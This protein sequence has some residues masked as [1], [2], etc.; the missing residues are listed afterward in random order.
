MSDMN[1]LDPQALCTLA[2]LKRECSVD[3]SDTGA[4][5]IFYYLINQVSE[6][7]RRHCN[8]RFFFD[9]E[10]AS[11]TSV[12]NA[13]SLAGGSLA[14]ATQPST[15]ALIVSITSTGITAGT[16]TFV[17][18]DPAGSAQ[19]DVYNFSTHGRSWSGVKLFATLTSITVAGLAG[20]VIT[21]KVSIG[22][23]NPYTEFHTIRKCRQFIYTR[24]APIQSIASLYD[25]S[26]GDYDSSTILDVDDYIASK[27]DGKIWRVT[28]NTPYEFESGIR[29]VKLVYTAGL[30]RDANV[31]NSPGLL[32]RMAMQIGA[33]Y[34]REIELKTQ[35]ISTKIDTSGAVLKFAAHVLTGAHITNEQRRM[36]S[37]FVR[38]RSR[39]AESDES[40]LGLT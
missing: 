18:T 28:S 26:N 10:V 34:Y 35:G 36:L 8:R 3:D 37:T 17:G 40:D 27:S 21:D 1:A 6:I 2:H 23:R 13:A 4:D 38:P 24:E 19:T 16:I 29:S 11:Q 5:D 22:V 7:L 15:Q 33:F 39:T 32:R 30:S 9:G 20:T 31:S 14:I 25:S 12:V